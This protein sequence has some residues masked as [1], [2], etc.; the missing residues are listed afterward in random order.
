MN[1]LTG[2]TAQCKHSYMSIS[3]GMISER[4]ELW[5]V[6]MCAAKSSVDLYQVGGPRSVSPK[7]W[8]DR[9][10]TDLSKFSW[11][12]E[13]IDVQYAKLV[14]CF[15]NNL[16]YRSS[17]TA[18]ST[19]WKQKS[20]AAGGRPRKLKEGDW[21]N[22]CSCLLAVFTTSFCVLFYIAQAIFLKSLLR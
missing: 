14:F 2:F 22:G 12:R 5:C 8:R 15:R 13:V 18:I 20:L 21:E 9:R 4:Q 19:L 17:V 7:V 1:S 6:A 16:S 10:R 11:E 3:A